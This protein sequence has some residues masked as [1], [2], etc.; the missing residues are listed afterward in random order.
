MS[1]HRRKPYKPRNTRKRNTLSAKEYLT[2]LRSIYPSC[3]FD[4]NGQECQAEYTGHKITYGE[5]EY[6]G[7][8]KLYEY[9]S[10]QFHNKIDAFIDVGSGRGK[11]CM[12]MASKPKIVSVLGVELVKQRHDD[13][14]QLKTELQSKY[15][16]KVEFINSD[17]LQIDFSPFKKRAVLV[18]FSNLCFDQSTTNSIFQKMSDDL[19]KGTIICCSKQPAHDGASPERGTSIGEDSQESRAWTGEYKSSIIIPMSW[20]SNSTV[21]IYQL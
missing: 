17:V 1:T 14:L 2:K 18:W 16:G 21:Y 6:E 9:T 3:Q 7:I 15:S 10:S 13:A 19:P 8:Q 5:M 12:Y 20:S 4:R 11:L